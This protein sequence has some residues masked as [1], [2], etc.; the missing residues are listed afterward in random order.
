MFLVRGSYKFHVRKYHA[1]PKFA[2]DTTK[3]CIDEYTNNNS[4]LG[5][6]TMKGRTFHMLH[7]I[8]TRIALAARSGKLLDFDP[9]NRGENRPVSKY[10]R[11]AAVMSCDLWYQL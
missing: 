10:A 9:R 8:L 3:Q 5:G 2:N 6:K 4:N 7:A 1:Q 11:N